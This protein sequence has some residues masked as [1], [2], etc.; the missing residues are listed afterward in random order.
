MFVDE[1]IK[2]PSKVLAAAKKIRDK[3][4]AKKAARAQGFTLLDELEQHKSK[5]MTKNVN[6]VEYDM[7]QFL[8]QCLDR[9]VELAGPNVKFKKVST[10]F[11]DDK[12]ARPIMD[13]AEAR[14]ELQPIASRVLMKVLF[15]ARMARFDLLRAT[16][17]LASRVTKWSPDCDKSLHRLMCYIHT[18]LDR[19]MVGFVG[20]PPEACKTWLFADSDH[21]GEHDNRSTSGCLL[22]LVGPNT[23]YPLTAFSKK[24]TSTAMSSTEAEVTAAN[25]A[26]RAVGLP[27]SC[28]WS[29]IR[30]AGG[31]STQQRPSRRVETR[32]K[33]PKDDYWEHSPFTNQ[34]TRV[35]VKPRNKLYNPID[36][37]CPVNLQGLA[38]QRYTIMKT[39]TGDVEFDLTWDW[40]TP[41]ADMIYDF[42]WAGKTVFRIPGPN[43][44]DYGVESREIRSALTDLNYTGSEKRGDES[45]YMAGPGSLEVIFLEDNQATIR[46]LES[47]R[48]PSFRHTDKTQRLNL[49]WLSEQFKRKHFR[50]VYVGSSLQAADILTKPFTN[51]EK[52]ESALRLMGISSQPLPRK[53]QQKMKACAGEPAPSTVSGSQQRAGEPACPSV[54]SHSR[55]LIEFCCGPDSKLGD[56][57]R[58]HSKDCYVIRCTEER[59]VT[60]RSNRMD[61]RNEVVRAIES[62]TAQPCPVLIWTSIPCTGGTT[63]SYVNLQH[64]SAKLKVEYHRHVFEKIWS[65]MVDFLNLIRHLSP[66]IAIEW[67]AHCIYWKFDR[68][69]K[70]CGKHQLIR[71]TFDGCMVGI[72]NKDGESIKKPWAIQTDCDSIVTAF[73]GLSCDGSHNHVQGRGHDLKETESYS[74]QMTDMIHRAFIAATSSK[75]EL[76]TST[77]LCAVSLSK[78]SS[79]MAYFRRFPEAE[80]EE[81]DYSA[82]VEAAGIRPGEPEST[83]E[84]VTLGPNGKAWYALTG[85]IFGSVT[86]CRVVNEA[87]MISDLT[88][89]M[90]NTDHSLLAKGYLRDVSPADAKL[91]DG[92][93]SFSLRGMVC[94]GEP[95]ANFIFAGDSS[96]ALVD[97]VDG[98]ASTRRNI[99]EYIKEKPDLLPPGRK[100]VLGTISNGVVGCLTSSRASSTLLNVCSGGEPLAHLSLSSPTLAT[101]FLGTTASST[102]IGLTR[103]WHATPR[104][105]VTQQTISWRKG[106]TPISP[107]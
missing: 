75:P 99:G 48:S 95:E 19:T 55:V 6:T 100:T 103:R 30:H 35:H 91:L 97:M 66:K 13:E 37:D 105:A 90:G 31:D 10:P 93:S 2:E 107:L 16:Q 76:T 33:N 87:D 43:E 85:S 34:V 57:S 18:T 86:R 52:W 92:V 67:P 11:P 49:S 65:S 83:A 64:E 81:A 68:V 60:S 5:C 77:A 22:A 96:M 89:I 29:V 7:R 44:V 102:V 42:E 54:A 38:R 70:F 4:G 15:A 27:S 73:D 45:V 36:S 80:V 14:G 8:Q 101:I 1:S 28:L 17:G 94:P 3:S 62:S 23:F 104:S 9:Y 41:D 59:D 61:I 78:S 79:T 72:V 98:Y 106:S 82:A 69:E 20:D 63:W 58:K 84:D 56:R 39:K 12:I 40:T 71:V 46:I 26:L 50:L 25:L 47:G 53:E 24:Q 51:S 74:F 32:A 88:S 21:A